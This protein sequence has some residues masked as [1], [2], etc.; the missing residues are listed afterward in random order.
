MLRFAL[1][2]LVLCISALGI[3]ALGIS[4]LGISALGLSV[5]ALAPVFPGPGW[6]CCSVATAAELA[7]AASATT[8][9]DV[10]GL[11]NTL[12]AGLAALALVLA[13]R[14]VDAAVA[15]VETNTRLQ[16]DDTNR[17][18]LDDLCHRGIDYAAGVLQQRL[19]RG[20]AI[21][22]RHGTVVAEAAA[23]VLAHAPEAAAGF[24]LDQA[25][26]MRMVT[27]RLAPAGSGGPAVAPPLQGVAGPSAPQPAAVTSPPVPVPGF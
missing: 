16:V 24:G 2:G 25:G 6:P 27:A 22:D 11:A 14:L 20:E 15:W 9:F 1:L 8:A 7:G 23:Y 17:A 3:S 10:S 26:I 18:V 4:A 5:L 19:A 13:R 21:L 12:I